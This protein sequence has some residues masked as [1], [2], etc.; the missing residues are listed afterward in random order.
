MKSKV[1]GVLCLL[2]TISLFISC[3]KDKNPPVITV[4]GINPANHCIGIDYVDQGATAQDEEDGDITDKINTSNNVDT[5][6]IGTY[7][8]VYTV[9]DKAGNSTT[10][11]RTVNVI[12]CK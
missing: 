10:V 9:E 6:Q 12:F 1:L 5:D 8:V 3:N 4:V 7:T 2:L 11:T